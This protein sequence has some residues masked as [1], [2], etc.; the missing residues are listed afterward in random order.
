MSEELLRKSKLEFKL[1]LHAVAL[2]MFM[3]EANNT[4]YSEIQ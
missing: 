1:D 3:L 2:Y 4:G